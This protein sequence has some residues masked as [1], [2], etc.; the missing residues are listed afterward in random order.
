VCPDWLWGPP[1]LL[2]NVCQGFSLA[3]KHGQV[4]M[5]TTHPHL[6]L[7]SRMSRS[8]ISSPPNCPMVCSGTGL[9]YFYYFLYRSFT[10]LKYVFVRRGLLSHD[11]VVSVKWFSFCCHLN[12]AG[13]PCSVVFK[14]AKNEFNIKLSAL[15]F[16][17][18]VSVV[19]L[20]CDAI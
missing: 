14:G 7:R 13:R 10:S 3:V 11:S 18:I 4:M 1:S 8:Y 6:V 2:S 5:L 17:M 16:V 9:L 15:K 19:L 12:I 20:G